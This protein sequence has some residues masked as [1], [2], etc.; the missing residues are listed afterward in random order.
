MNQADGSVSRVDPT[1][2]KATA[3]IDVGNEIHGGDIAVGGGNVWVRGGPDMLAR[4]DP[5]SD[6]VTDR[7]KPHPGSGSVA[8]DDN[9]VWVTAHDVALIWR[10]PLD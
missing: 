4:I 9:A 6:L 10:L 1:T 5:A 8:A 2:D 7:Y 3:T